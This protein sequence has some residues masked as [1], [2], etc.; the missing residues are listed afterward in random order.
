[1]P[2]QLVDATSPKLLSRQCFSREN[3]SV[4]LTRKLLPDYGYHTETKEFMHSPHKHWLDRGCNSPFFVAHVSLNEEQCKVLRGQRRCSASYPITPGSKEQGWRDLKPLA[5][6][7]DVL[8]VHLSLSMQDLGH[9]TF[10]AEQRRQVFL[11]E[12]VRDHQFG[13]HFYRR[14]RADRVMFLFVGLD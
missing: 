6:F 4:G 14:E 13:K 9:D 10:R 5:E 7:F 1:M 2:A 8:L 11:L 12:V 3:R